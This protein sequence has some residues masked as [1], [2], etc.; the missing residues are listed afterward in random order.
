ME[1][2]YVPGTEETDPKKQNMALQQLGAA[3]KTIGDT[4][5]TNTTNIATN[6]AAIAANTAAILPAATQANQE[7]ATSNAVAVTP[8]RQQYHP[9]HPKAW[10]YVT[11]AAGIYTL[12]VSFGVTSITKSSTGLVDV[13]L[14]TAFS[15]TSFAVIAMSNAGGAYVSETIGSRTTTNFRTSIRTDAGANVDASFSVMFFGDQ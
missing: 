9:A 6:T 5:A 8:G 12:A 14:S 4:V 3:A 1:P 15:S 11:E 2:I 10:A 13:T 7:T